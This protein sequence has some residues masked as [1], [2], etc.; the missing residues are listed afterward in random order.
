MSK[1]FFAFWTFMISKWQP[2]PSVA[3]SDAVKTEYIPQTTYY[4][5]NHHHIIS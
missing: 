3:F 5:Y 1:L 2:V 4:Y